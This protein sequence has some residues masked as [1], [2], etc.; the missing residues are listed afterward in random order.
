[1]L[2]KKLCRWSF[3]I[4]AAQLIAPVEAPQAQ[5][6]GGRYT[7]L[8]SERSPNSFA[9]ELSSDG[10]QVVEIV[11]DALSC[12]FGDSHTFTINP[13]IP[14]TGGRFSAR[15]VP[16]PV[17]PD[18]FDPHAHTLDIDGV[19]FDADGNGTPEQALGGLSFVSGPN[20][21][22]FRW[23]ATQAAADSD[24]DGWSDGGEQR[25]G[26]EQRG[27]TAFGLGFSSTPE[28]REVRTTCLSGPGPCRDFA[29]NDNFSD[30]DGLFDGNEADGPDL[31]LEP[32]CANPMPEEDL[33]APIIPPP[34]PPPPPEVVLTNPQA[35]IRC[36]GSGCRPSITCNLD[37]QQGIPCSNPIDL[38]ALVPRRSGLL[39]EDAVAKAP[40]R[41]RFAFGVAN[42]PPE[43]TATVR[44]RLTRAGKRIVRTSKKRRL[45]GIFEVRNTPGDLIDTRVRIRLK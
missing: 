21:C 20:R 6:P 28:H 34:P 14:V 42:V 15:D 40:R 8:F 30:R 41:I 35:P 1:M 4:L 24:G 3:V 2:S 12:S 11:S 39:G 31:D 44:L 7:G 45:S 19:F 16:V 13:G 23:V 18:P 25:L 27:Q 29:D 37:Q 32:D 43:G 5:I 33:C 17:D 22:N 9:L 26:S 10:S 36:T 38:F